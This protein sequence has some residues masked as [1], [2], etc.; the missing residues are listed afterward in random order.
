MSNPSVSQASFLSIGKCERLKCY[1]FSFIPSSALPFLPT[2][3]L[4]ID[5]KDGYMGMLLYYILKSGLPFVEQMSIPQP[6]KSLPHTSYGSL[7]W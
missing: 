7:H 6:S 4:E 5:F 2:A 3:V 1:E